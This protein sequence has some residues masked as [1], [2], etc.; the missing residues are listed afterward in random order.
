MSS[1]FC[2]TAASPGAWDANLLADQVIVKDDQFTDL[3][4]SRFLRNVDGAKLQDYI[5]E[6]RWQVSM[7]GDFEQQPFGFLKV[8]HSAKLGYQIRLFIF[9]PDYIE[10]SQ[11]MRDFNQFLQYET[12]GASAQQQGR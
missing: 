2:S 12:R 4:V 8:L 5:S 9:P 6:H 3:F 7:E 11:L 1:E 10:F